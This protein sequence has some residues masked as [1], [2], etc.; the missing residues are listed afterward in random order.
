VQTSWGQPNPDVDACKNLDTKLRGLTRSL[1]SWS[2]SRVGNVTAQLAYAR[3]IIHEFD[4]AQES[5]RPS[6]G[7]QVLHRDLKAHVLGLASLARTMARQCAR[8][9]HLREG[10]A[11][12]KYFHLQACHR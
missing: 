6:A 7:E 8:T 3:A 9:R 1:R 12:T 11:C 4:V 5:R 2:A 10:D